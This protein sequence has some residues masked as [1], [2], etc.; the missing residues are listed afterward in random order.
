MIFVDDTTGFLSGNGTIY[1]TTDGGG[2]WNPSNT[3]GSAGRLVAASRDTVWSFYNYDRLVHTTNGGTTWSNEFR[4]SGGQYYGLTFADSRHGF[5]A[6][7]IY[8]WEHNRPDAAA[9]ARTSD[10]GGTWDTVYPTGLENRAI[11]GL[12]ALNSDTL[13]AAGGGLFKTENGGNRWKVIPN[14]GASGALCFPDKLH[15]T[16]VGYSGS[17]IHS[18]DGGNSWQ[19]QTSP[20]LGNFGGVVFADSSLGYACGSLGTIIKTINGG[21]SWVNISPTITNMILVSVYPQPSDGPITLGYN[22]PETGHVSLWV[23]NVTGAVVSNI[24]NGVLQTPGVQSVT[25]DVSRFASGTYTYVLQT[26]KYYATG[27]I[28]VIH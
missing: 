3:N 14:S 5:I 19:R 1:K 7:D 24:L 25:V 12:A 10:G 28:E 13:F 15:G 21:V 23:N 8:A 26:E 4:F 6:G 2:T 20:Y 9:F 16:A 18:S 27:K 17:I 11:L 22:L